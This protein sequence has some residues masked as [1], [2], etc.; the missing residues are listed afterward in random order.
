MYSRKIVEANQ[1]KLEAALE[2]K[3]VRYPVPEVEERVDALAGAIDDK[4]KVTRI[5]TKEEKE[6][7]RNERLLTA[8]DFTYWVERY[9]FALLDQG[10]LGRIQLW[11]SQSI[12]LR[13]IAKLEDEMLDKQARGEP[14]DGILIA[15]HK[16][17]Q[18][19]ATLLSR[20]IIIHRLISQ[21]HTRSMAA[22]LDDDKILE[23]YD[24]DKTIIENLPWWLRPSLGFDEKA[25]HIFFDKLNSRVIYQT[26][27]QKF[28]VGQGRQFDVNHLTEVA[29]WP[30]PDVIE[31]DFFPTIPQSTRALCLLESTA[32][33][34][35]NWWHEFC[36]RIRNGTSRRWNFLFVP[37][38]AE[39][40]K[41]RAAPS[42]DWKPTD[43]SMAHAKKI[44]ETSTE[45]I[46]KQVM[47]SREQ[48]YWWETTRAEY[49]SAD[50]LNLFYTNYPS[51]PEESFQH[52]KRS[53]FSAVTLERLRAETGVGIPYQIGEVT[54]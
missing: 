3:L 12:A 27:N 14:V 26:G 43:I 54:L 30:Y 41:Y 1:G 36:T 48:L 50:N 17:R 28:G 5:L 46:G 19:G 33:G 9:A 6:F 8:I 25:Q 45:F 20:A 29:S 47:I 16:A 42:A 21:K 31:H 38:Y 35:R 52:S 51:T 53:A 49:Q 24:R 39:T 2:T 4:G 22:S 34:R 44:H 37:W 7:I 18:L 23:L 13:L 11:E 40:K 15:F 10:G 32:Q